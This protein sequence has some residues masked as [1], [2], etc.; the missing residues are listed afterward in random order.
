MTTPEAVTAALDAGVDALGFV[1]AKSVRRVSPEAALEL[2]AP[3]RGKVLCVAVTRHPLQR[4]VDE[5]LAVFKPDVLQTDVSDLGELQLPAQLELLPVLR[6]TAHAVFPARVL[7]EGP[8]S[9]TGVT[10]DWTEAQRVAR[11]T[12]VVLAGGLNP[13]N[14]AAAIAAVRPFGVDVSTGVEARPGVKSPAAI[15]NFVS[16]ARV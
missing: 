11:R 3:A 15:A 2:A 1:F 5:M 14:V 10:C 16:A 8:A 9:G 7:F 6:S 12:Q 13:G 4:D